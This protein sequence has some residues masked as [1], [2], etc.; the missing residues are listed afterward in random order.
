MSGRKD[1]HKKSLHPSATSILKG[2]AGTEGVDQLLALPKRK[3][4]SPKT[5]GAVPLRWSR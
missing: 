1:S 2:H 3:I 4:C 5:S